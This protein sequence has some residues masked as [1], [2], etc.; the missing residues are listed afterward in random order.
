MPL[1]FNN[2][3]E[4]IKLYGKVRPNSGL[5]DVLDVKLPPALTERQ[6]Q[7]IF[8]YDSRTARARDKDAV[9]VFAHPYVCFLMFFLYRKILDA[10]TT[11][12]SDNLG[13]WF[14]F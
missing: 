13:N 5:S 8:L 14:I 7:S 3:R 4:R 6:G 10:S 11:C 1:K 9:F 12:W 2:F